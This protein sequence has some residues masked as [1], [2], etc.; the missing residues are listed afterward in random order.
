MSLNL[1]FNHNPNKNAPAAVTVTIAL[2]PLEIKTVL[3][4]ITIRLLIALPSLH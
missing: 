3:R 4:D 2:G 1:L